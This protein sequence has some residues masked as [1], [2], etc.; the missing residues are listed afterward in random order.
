MTEYVIEVR[1]GAYLALWTSL[2]WSYTITDNVDN[3][4]HFKS[5][6]EAHIRA[7]M[8]DVPDTY[9][10]L[11]VEQTQFLLPLSGEVNQYAGCLNKR[12]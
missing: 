12:Q 2:D 8:L 10:V 11:P 3:A 7:V 5:A 1:T 4:C 9:G 6:T